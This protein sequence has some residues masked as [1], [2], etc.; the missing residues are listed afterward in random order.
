VSNHGARF[1]GGTVIMVYVAGAP[2]GHGVVAMGAG[3]AP[4]LCLRE[5]GRPKLPLH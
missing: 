2:S 5:T 4:V 3:N 1:Y